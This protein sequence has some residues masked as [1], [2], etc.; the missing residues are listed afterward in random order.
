MKQHQ[1]VYRHETAYFVFCFLLKVCFVGLSKFFED[2]KS[3]CG[4]FSQGGMKN[5]AGGR[6]GVLSLTWRRCQSHQPKTVETAGVT[7]VQHR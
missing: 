7:G 6:G 3:G 5:R 4:L 1:M 2:Q